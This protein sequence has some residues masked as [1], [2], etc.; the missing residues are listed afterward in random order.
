MFE[1]LL[2]SSPSPIECYSKFDVY[3]SYTFPY[4]FTILACIQGKKREIG[5]G[6][7]ICVGGHCFV[8]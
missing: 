1:A 2:L 5:R 6:V 8:F 7:C 4:K 3:Y